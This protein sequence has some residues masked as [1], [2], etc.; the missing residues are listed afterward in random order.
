M[1]RLRCRGKQA[2]GS[3]NEMTLDV[4]VRMC[5]KVNMEMKT[6][7]IIAAAVACAPLIRK[8]LYL[9]P[10]KAVHDYLWRNVKNERVRSVLFKQI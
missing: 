6:G 8:Y 1:V 10:A 2:L 7:L 5:Y 4:L 9:R 3:G